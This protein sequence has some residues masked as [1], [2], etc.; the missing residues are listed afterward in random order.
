MQDSSKIKEYSMTDIAPTISRLLGIRLPANSEGKP[1]VDVIDDMG[2]QKRLAVIVLDAFGVAT[3]KRYSELTPNFNRIAKNNLLHIRSVVPAK[4]P[5]NFATMASGASSDSHKIRDRSEKLNVETVFHVI[6][7]TNM[8]SAAVGRATSTMGILLSKFAYY[9]C[10]A[11]SNLDEDLFHKGL[12]LIGNESPEFILMQLL[13]IDDTG[14]KFGIMSDE[15]RKAVSTTDSRLGQFFP[16]LAEKN[17]SLM[18]LADHGAHQAEGKATHNGS[19]ED[20]LIVPLT[21]C[22]WGWLEKV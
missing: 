18:V 20:D 5:V 4:T 14:H 10:L 2:K 16:I 13:D 7:E 6:A 17:Y 15:F 21:W 9:K 19:V 1:I 12:D 11:E 3:W 8:K 22:K